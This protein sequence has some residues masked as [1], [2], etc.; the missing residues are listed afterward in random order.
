MNN[1]PS[2]FQRSSRFLPWLT[3][4]LLTALVAGCGGGGGGGRDPILGAGDIGNVAGAPTVTL[5]APLPK[6]TGVPINTK[7]ITAAFSEAMDPATL[8]AA[9]FTLACPAGTP[10]TGAVSYL[11]TGNVATLTLPAGA[12]LPPSTVCTATI[13]TAAKDATGVPLASNFVWTFTTGL[14]TD[15]TPPTVT[16]TTNLNGATG[17]A[18]NTKIVF[19]YSEPI[20]P[21]TI[22]ATT[23]TV[24]QGATAVAGTVTQT[25]LTSI[26]TP[27]SN[28]TANKRKDKS[29]R[30]SGF[31]FP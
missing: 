7:I 5:V 4:L 26:F 21:L 14:A 25:G 19:T 6:A 24:K 11:A 31:G 13:T 23:F 20:D 12:N 9:S 30:E 1:K 29:V 15:T 16:G 10:V 3:A 8:T 27:A 2:E 28:L 18:V 22:N 17:V